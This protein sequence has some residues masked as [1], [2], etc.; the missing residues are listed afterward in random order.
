MPCGYREVK[1]LEDLCIQSV[2]VIEFG[3]GVRVISQVVDI[4]RKNNPK[5]CANQRWASLPIAACGMTLIDVDIPFRADSK[6]CDF[7]GEGTERRFDV[8]N[9]P[10]KSLE[11]LCIRVVSVSTF[12][13]AKPRD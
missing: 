4:T 9:R 1:A 10:A 13:P 3:A 7:K 5:H 11:T 8:D 12:K 6:P 2:R